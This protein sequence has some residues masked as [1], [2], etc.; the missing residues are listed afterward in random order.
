MLNTSGA[1]VA[2]RSY[3]PFGAQWA[4]SGSLP[5]DFGF[6]GQREADEIGLYYYVARWLDPEIAHFAQADTIIPDESSAISWNRY[7]YVDYNPVNFTDPTGHCKT[8]DSFL[9]CI[10]KEYQKKLRVEG[11]NGLCWQGSNYS[12]C[13]NDERILIMEENHVIDEEQ[14]IELE[15]NVYLT[16][17][18][19]T[20]T[21][22][23]LP[24]GASD[25]I[26]DEDGVIDWRIF[27]DFFGR[28][29]LFDTPFYNGD[30]EDSTVIF[31]GLPYDR[32][33]VN[34]FAQGMWGARFGSS[35]E[36]VINLA[37][38][39]KQ[40]EYSH[41]LSED[42]IFWITKGYYDYLTIQEDPEAWIQ[43]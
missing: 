30:L 24:R 38:D 33:D 14:F 25:I 8:G 23:G 19:M 1:Q 26:G 41:G 34:Y 27:G 9:D 17:E 3:L 42:E 36:D 16:L 37:S 18:N 43:Q 12:E 21:F 31:Q 20:E 2:R 15:Y 5:T 11:S 32:S 40:T 13:F 22:L 39:W 28:R 4:A 29:D 10:I 7:A 35:L 6:T